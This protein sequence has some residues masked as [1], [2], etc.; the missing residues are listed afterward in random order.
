MATL[1]PQRVVGKEQS[2]DLAGVVESCNRFAFD[3][4]SKLAGQPGNLF[5]SPSS[6]ATALA[7]TFAGANHATAD[8]MAELLHLGLP[9]NRFHDGFLHLRKSTRTGGVELRVANR[10]WGQKGYPYLADFQ[11]TTERCYEARLAEVDFLNAGDAARLQINAWVEEQTARKI[12]DLIPAGIITP[13]TRLVLTNAIYFKG[14]WEHE[15]D[16]ADTQ[17]AAFWI[18]SGTNQ[19]VRM[20]RQTEYF[21]YGE[22][23]DL[24]ILEMPYRGTQFE[25]RSTADGGRDA[26]E[27]PESGS[28]LAM[29]ILLPR[30]N[31]GLPQIESRLSSATL[32]QWTELTTN[33]VRVTIP[34]FKIESEFLLNET[35]TALGMR[36]AFSPEEADFSRMSDHPE[37]LYLAAAIH[38]AFVDVNEQGTE[39]AAASAMVMMARG[40]PVMQEPK[41][42]RAD[43][44][45]LFLIRDRETGLIHFLGRV[46]EL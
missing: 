30:R 22:I 16:K 9:E 21:E 10:L 3:L 24:Q 25:F 6:I 5:I 29:C 11:S 31:D 4:Y 33:R 46:T 28:D 13:L 40:L 7:M 27:N 17:A 26:V 41:V 19:A 44:P 8:E 36:Q 14:S 37:G 45:F 35:L 43:H 38:K 23:E 1:D 15:F 18:D 34:Q 2:R 42:F 12:T 20:M 39:A 32:R